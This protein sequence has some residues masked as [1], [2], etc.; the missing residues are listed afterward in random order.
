MESWCSFRRSFSCRDPRRPIIWIGGNGPAAMTARSNSAT[1]ASDVA[2]AEL[3]ANVEELHAGA[4]AAGR[5]VPEIHRAAGTQA[6]RHFGGAR[7]KSRQR[8][9]PAQPILYLTWGVTP[10]KSP[11]EKSV[12]TFMTKSP[13]RCTLSAAQRIEIVRADSQHLAIDA[14]R[15]RSRSAR[16]PAH[17][18]SRRPSRTLARRRCLSTFATCSVFPFEVHSRRAA[19]LRI[20]GDVL[21]WS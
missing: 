8:R 11:F 21:A 16:E 5:A 9:K 13:A 3:K 18:L 20:F 4:L 15:C 17:D 14:T 1:V 12:Q 10:T 6:R 2:C 19:V 7:K